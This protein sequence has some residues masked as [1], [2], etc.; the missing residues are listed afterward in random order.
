MSAPTAMHICNIHRAK[1]TVGKVSPSAQL[2]RCG[3]AG[4]KNSAIY[5]VTHTPGQE[6]VH[7]PDYRNFAPPNE[8]LLNFSAR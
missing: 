7:L 2:G 3:F 8:R 1:I 5:Q 4:C 6:V